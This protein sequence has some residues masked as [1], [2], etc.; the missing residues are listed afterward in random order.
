M[1]LP[2]KY[3]S[4]RNKK[5]VRA[6]YIKLQDGKCHHCGNPI[7]GEPTEKI[8]RM[9]I[10]RRLFPLKF[11]DCPIHLHHDHDSDMTIGVVHAKCN[12]VLWQYHGE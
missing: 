10:D 1:H 9:V 4:C 3:S 6:E 11:F 7:D 2:V 5:K 12:A 8:K